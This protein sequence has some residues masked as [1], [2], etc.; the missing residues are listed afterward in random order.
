MD[1]DVANRID[2]ALRTGAR[3]IDLS[4]CGLKSLPESLEKLTG[5]TT[6]KLSGNHLAVL[7]EFLGN[8]TA[9]TSLDLSYNQLT[10][11]PESLENL[12]P[13]TELILDGNQL[14][15]LPEFL[16]D[17]NVLTRQNSLAATPERTISQLIAQLPSSQ[18]AEDSALLD[19]VKSRIK[20]VLAENG[21]G[22][23]NGWDF[24]SGN[25]N[26]FVDVHPDR[27]QQAFDVVRRALT[28]LTLQD[29]AVIAAQ[30]TSEDESADDELIVLWPPNFNGTFNFW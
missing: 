16:V 25:M 30:V 10:V 19:V 6:L 22:T 24:G 20:D 15:E 13:L 8:L 21:S 14:T 1:A 27:S 7:P 3:E 12:T 11:L 17:L 5:L 2:E 28:D 26:V 29:T 4:Y 23:V 9:L 18:S